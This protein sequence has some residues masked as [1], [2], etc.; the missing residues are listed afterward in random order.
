MTLRHLVVKLLYMRNYSTGRPFRPFR[1]QLRHGEHLVPVIY[2]TVSFRK[3]INLKS[4]SLSAPFSL[5]RPFDVQIDTTMPLRR[6]YNSLTNYKRTWLYTKIIS[7]SRFCLLM[8]RD[9]SPEATCQQSQHCLHGRPC[10]FRWA[11]DSIQR[12]LK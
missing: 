9:I 2:T 5:R 3:P 1:D 8:Y 7:C 11:I 10:L 12:I 6:L 4:S